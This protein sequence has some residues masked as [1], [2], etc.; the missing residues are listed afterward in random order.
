MTRASRS[1]WP[2]VVVDVCAILALGSLAVVGVLDARIAAL[3]IGAVQGAYVLQF[4]RGG[5]PPVGA[6]VGALSAAAAFAGRMWGT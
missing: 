6:I 2:H 1:H 5:S 4:R 3:L